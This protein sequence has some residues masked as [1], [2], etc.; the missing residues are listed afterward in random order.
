MKKS[1]K[2]F[3]ENAARM[4]CGMLCAALLLVGCAAG[5]DGSDSILTARPSTNSGAAQPVQGA[6]SG[7]K[8]GYVEEKLSILPQ[9]EGSVLSLTHRADGAVVAGG[10]TYGGITPLLYTS[11]D[12]TN[13]QQVKNN[14]VEEFCAQLGIADYTWATVLPDGTWWLTVSPMYVAP[15]DVVGWSTE[16]GDVE[17]TNA[18]ATGTKIYRFGP[19]GQPEE[20]TYDLLEKA[21][22]TGAY[23]P[24][25]RGLSQTD[26]GLLVVQLTD[27]VAWSTLYYLVVDAATGEQ[28]CQLELPTD[29]FNVWNYALHGDELHMIDRQ[30]EVHAFD[31]RSGKELRTYTGPPMDIL[32]SWNFDIDKDGAFCYYDKTGL[33]RM[34]PGGSLVQDLVVGG[35][36]YAFNDIDFHPYVFCAMDDGSFLTVAYTGQEENHLRYVFDPDYVPVEV[37]GLTVWALEEDYAVRV[38]AAAFEEA[39]P[40]MP[41]TL[42]FGR[43]K[44]G[45]G[46]AEDVVRALN[47]RLLA[48]DAPDVLIVDGLP[49]DSYIKAGALMDLTGAF[50]VSN[51]YE[52]VMKAYERE[53]KTYAYPMRFRLPLFHAP[54]GDAK[55]EAVETLQDIADL[56][57]EEGALFYSSYSN[58][59]DAL[60]AGYSPVIFP[61]AAAVDEEAVRAFLTATGLIA[62]NLGLTQEENYRHGGYSDFGQTHPQGFAAYN[63]NGAAYAADIL[64]GEDEITF[65]F[66]WNG[67]QMMKPIP[68]GSYIPGC[69]A[70]I[71]VNAEKPEE[72]KK[73]IQLM[74]SDTVSTRG[75]HQGFPVNRELIQPYFEQVKERGTGWEEEAKAEAADYDWDGLIEKLTQPAI[76]EAVLKEK[77][78]EQALKYY[79]GTHGIDA[80]VDAVVQNTRLYFQE[81]A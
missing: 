55:G 24:E 10:R 30:G 76:T 63:E 78:Y 67:E 5:G 7:A 80:A 33:H 18:D 32:E 59:F 4:L 23:Y 71:P 13:W 2:H 26:T 19:N 75:M 25:V 6:A 21:M 12:G 20:M 35:S 36:G 37:D 22:E 29:K 66:Q 28:V 39:N 72:A 17:L 44:E 31:L 70:A 61:D 74:L 45:G 65:L 47:T 14:A 8:G 68:V 73:F 38:V 69:A 11:V 41:V 42:E 81:R 49:V 57:N 56:T 27:S 40:D 52:N 58:M 53:G 50:D 46:T 15:D 1:A 51:C 60:Y 34:E 54:A 79:E 16:N 62:E 43:V 77:L 9:E 48:D 3:A 64:S